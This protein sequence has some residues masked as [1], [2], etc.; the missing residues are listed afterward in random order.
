[1][2][3]SITR[4]ATAFLVLLPIPPIIRA[5]V[6]KWRTTNPPGMFGRKRDR[7]ACDCQELELV[8]GLKS[9]VT[10][11]ICQEH[12]RMWL[13]RIPELAIEPDVRFKEDV[14]G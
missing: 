2:I 12:Q 9:G 7:T 4:R 11:A 14:V 6:L 8:A 5:D 10:Y 1:M 3:A 13:I